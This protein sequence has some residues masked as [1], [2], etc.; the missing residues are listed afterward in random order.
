MGGGKGGARG[1]AKR[2]RERRENVEGRLPSLSLLLCQWLRG[3]PEP[4]LRCAAPRG[5]AA[6]AVAAAFLFL[7]LFLCLFLWRF[8]ALLAVPAAQHRRPLQSRP[9]AAQEGV[10]CEYVCVCV[11]MCVCVC[12]RPR[13]KGWSSP[14]FFSL[15]S[16][17]LSQPLLS[18]SLFFFSSSASASPSLRSTASS[19]LTLIRASPDT[20]W[21]KSR[22]FFCAMLAPFLSHWLTGQLSSAR[23]SITPLYLAA[24]SADP[25]ECSAR[26]LGLTRQ[27]TYAERS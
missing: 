10:R 13:E 8:L 26:S 27:R 18:L 12:E 22:A 25:R 9:T 2:E 15:S 17:T 20:R 24:T 6:A 16:S 21:L 23:R 1:K 7:A 4:M 5:S 14:T 11:C 19:A 3:S